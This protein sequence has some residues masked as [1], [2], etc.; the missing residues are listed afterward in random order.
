[1]S[2]SP[3]RSPTAGCRSYSRRRPTPRRAPSLRGGRLRSPRAVAAGELRDR[4]AAR[5]DPAPRR[6][7][8]G[9][10][11]APDDRAVRRR[12][13]REGRELPPERDRP[14]GYSDAADRIQ[15]LY[16]AGKKAEAIAAVPT[17]LWRRS[18]SSVRRRIRDE[19]AAWEESVVTTMLVQGP[20]FALRTIRDVVQGGSLTRAKLGGVG[21]RV[22]DPPLGG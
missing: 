15:E 18:R 6:G 21:V 22:C 14:L 4:V 19:L 12:H 7:E 1:M 20:A 13:G 11:G 10:H 16:L 17:K 5:R 9:R 8:G 2:P 3:R